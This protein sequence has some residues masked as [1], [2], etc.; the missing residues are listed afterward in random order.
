MYKI[1]Y[2]KK[3]FDYIIGS[4]IYISIISIIIC[5]GTMKLFK[6]ELNRDYIIL[7][8]FATLSSYSLHWYFTK[9]HDIADSVNYNQFRYEFNK[10]NKKILFTQF[11]LS[12]FVCIYILWLHQNW[13]LYILPAALATL[14][15]SAPKYPVKILKYLEGRALIK[16]FYLA[17]VWIY[18]TNIIPIILSVVALSFTMVVY[19]I[20]NFIL[21]YIICLL[22]DYR[23]REKEKIKYI[24]IDNVK[25]FKKIIIYL[26]LLFL[27]LII[28]ITFFTK[29][30]IIVLP[31]LIPFIILYSTLSHS[32]T[33]KSDYWYYFFL[34]GLMCSPSIIIIILNYCNGFVL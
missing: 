22:F 29:S 13:L 24:F 6:L 9:F 15:Y 10:K 17:A 3:I 33:T 7:V 28:G 12:F 2:L 34:D 19:L 26:S 32:I 30:I 8:F 23:D 16:T 25:H 11:V 21:I 18:V 14:I 5:I 27:L 4:N 31:I 20:E 1:N